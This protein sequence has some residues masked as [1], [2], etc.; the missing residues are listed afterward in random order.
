MVQ[1]DF[2]P[3]FGFEKFPGPKVFGPKYFGTQKVCVKQ[4]GPKS[5]VKIGSVTAEI[6]LIWTN[7]ARINVVW[8]DFSVTVGICSRVSQEPT[9]KILLK[10]GEYRLRYCRHG[11]F[12]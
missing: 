3:K 12:H 9:I 7:V 10:S 8:T 11:Y 2:G 1:K 6:F 5:L 4:L